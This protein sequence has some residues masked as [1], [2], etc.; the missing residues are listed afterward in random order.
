M[1]FRQQQ[2]DQVKEALLLE[3]RKLNVRQ[4]K[5]NE[6][7]QEKKETFKIDDF[8]IGRMQ[9]QYHYILSLE[10]EIQMAAAAVI[11]QQQQV[12]QARQ[13]LV[14]AKK[15]SQVLEKLEEKQYSQYLLD[16]KHQEQLVLDEIANR[17]KFS[18]F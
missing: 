9:L 14:A 12:E 10:H 4:Q 6:L 15:K 8:N 11:Q 13:R 17:K 3:Q 18:L 5:L 1:D 2:T 7:Q 16:S